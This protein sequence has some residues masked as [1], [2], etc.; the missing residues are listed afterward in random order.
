MLIQTSSEVRA[1][2]KRGSKSAHS[3]RYNLSAASVA[4]PYLIPCQDVHNNGTNVC[5]SHST[6]V[7]PNGEPYP[8]EPGWAS[9][10]ILGM[11]FAGAIVGMCG[12]GYLGDAIGR[13]RAMIA[14]LSFTFLSVEALLD[15]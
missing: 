12:M 5:Q 2:S 14:T 15:S 13:R 6:Q 9:D 3:E 10:V 11:V 8:D 7:A 4:I 1:S